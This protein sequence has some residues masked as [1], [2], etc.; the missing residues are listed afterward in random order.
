MICTYCL[1]HDRTSEA[2]SAPVS[3]CDCCF[4]NDYHDAIS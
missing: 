1:L 2:L 4:I 3:P